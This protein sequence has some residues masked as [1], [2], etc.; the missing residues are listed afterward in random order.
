MTGITGNKLPT[1]REKTED[2]L[3]ENI[4]QLGFCGEGL[5]EERSVIFALRGLNAVNIMCTVYQT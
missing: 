5:K 2:E 3:G 4:S 1:P